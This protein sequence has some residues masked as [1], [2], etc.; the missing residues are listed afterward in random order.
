MIVGI[1]AEQPPLDPVSGAGRVWREAV[2]RLD[3]RV[4]LEEVPMSGRRWFRRGPDVWLVNGHEVAFSGSARVTVVNHGAAWLNEQRFWELVPRA[5]AEPVVRAA[6]RSLR[7]ATVVITPSEYTR[8]AIVDRLPR[9][10]ESVV[11]VPHGV[12][13]DVFHPGATGGHDAVRQALGQDLPYVLF[14]SLPSIAQKNLQALKDA[15]AVLAR[16]GLPHALVIAGG[17]A[18][19][20]SEEL[21]ASIE[22]DVPGA[23]GRVA[24]LGHQSDLALAGLMAGCAAFCLPSFFESFG[25]TALEAMA[26]GAPTVVAAAGALPEVVAD[27]GLTAQPEAG[28]L[29]RELRRVLTDPHLAARLRADGRR[30]ALDMSWDVTADGWQA[31]LERAAAAPTVG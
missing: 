23:P 14:A 10:P 1:P 21:L 20:E 16:Q 25:L 4:R 8:R 29:A 12:D 30:R 6:E 15:M 5:Y 17:R 27:A 13:A 26:C 28:A 19:G 31:A 11:A 22:A 18:G 7:A 2:E 3:A 9:P 24:W